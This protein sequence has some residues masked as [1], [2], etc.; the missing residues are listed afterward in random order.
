MLIE[1]DTQV[2]SLCLDLAEVLDKKIS[3]IQGLDYNTA[4]N[5][6]MDW[7]DSCDIAFNSKVIADDGAIATEVQLQLQIKALAKGYQV[8]QWL[9]YFPVKQPKKRSKKLLLT[10][11]HN[12]I[13]KLA[14]CRCN[15]T[16]NFDRRSQP[17][18]ILFVPLHISLQLR[19]PLLLNFPQLIK[20]PIVCSD[21]STNE[22]K[23]DI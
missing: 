8:E 16:L 13:I 15:C 19:H 20:I 9:K 11:I 21:N 6:F 3:R 7:S 22:T 23:N 4:V 10:R 2:D 1:P 17:F 12:R 5:L 18:D 14:V